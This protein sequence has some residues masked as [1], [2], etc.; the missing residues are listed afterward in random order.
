MGTEMITLPF[1]TFMEHLAPFN[2]PTED[3]EKL[4]CRLRGGGLVSGDGADLRFTNIEAPFPSAFHPLLAICDSI[5]HAPGAFTDRETSTEYRHLGSSTQWHLMIEG[6][7]HEVDA[8]FALC[9]SRVPGPQKASLYAADVAVSL[10]LRRGSEDQ[11]VIGVR[12]HHLPR[13]I[14]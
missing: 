4:L 11:R 13:P 7:P 3:V 8:V 2:P 9:P 1:E 5:A 6:S 14:Y 10:E 12:C